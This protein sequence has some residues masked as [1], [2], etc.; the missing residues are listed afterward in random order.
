M[1]VGH[2]GKIAFATNGEIMGK[3]RKLTAKERREKELL[4][5]VKKLKAAIA[6]AELESE[7]LKS[8]I[9][10]VSEDRRKRDEAAAAVSLSPSGRRPKN[11]AVRP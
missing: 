8:C 11:T 4:D 5:E 10:R 3:M 6:Q 9:F 2:R 7:F 1:R